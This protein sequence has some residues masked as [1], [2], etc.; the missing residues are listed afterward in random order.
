MKKKCDICRKEFE[1]LCVIH[2]K[3]KDGIDLRL[4]PECIKMVCNEMERILLEGVKS[5]EIY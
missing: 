1:N 2:V 3:K 4:C 5:V